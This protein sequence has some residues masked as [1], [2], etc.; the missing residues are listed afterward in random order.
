MTTEEPSS[1]KQPP[2]VE[3]SGAPKLPWGWTEKQDSDGVFYYVANTGETSYD[4]PTL[5]R[6]AVK[7]AERSSAPEWTEL[8]DSRTNERGLVRP[9]NYY[10]YNNYSGEIVTDK[11]PLYAKQSQ[12]DI[13][14]YLKAAIIIQ[15]MVRNHQGRRRCRVQRAHRM[16]LH[17]GSHLRWE[18][19]YD[20]HHKL[21]Y[22]FDLT[23]GVIRWDEPEQ[24][25]MYDY[26]LPKEE[27]KNYPK[28]S[29][30]WDPRTRVHYYF[31]NYQGTSQ[32]DI[33]FDW[34]NVMAAD[35]RRPPI[36][37]SALAMQC[38][39]RNRVIAQRIR[40]ATNA[41]NMS[42]ADRQKEVAAR[43]AD[44]ARK[45]A[46]AIIRRA[47]E[48]ER[49]AN[50]AMARAEAEQCSKGDKFWGIDFMIQAQKHRLEVERRLKLAEEEKKRRDE[51]E[52]Q[53]AIERRQEMFAGRKVEML[54]ERQRNKEMVEEERQ[55]TSIDRFWGVDRAEIDRK[56]RC[57]EMVVQDAESRERENYERL[58]ALHTL[59]LNEH[60]DKKRAEDLNKAR[61]QTATRE[62]YMSDFYRA[63]SSQNILSYRWPS[64]TFVS[65]LPHRWE[66]N[67]FRMDEV[68]DTTRIDAPA[69]VFHDLNSIRSAP[70]KAARDFLLS[71]DSQ[72]FNLLPHMHKIIDKQGVPPEID[73]R[74]ILSRQRTASSSLM[75]SNHLEWLELTGKTMPHMPEINANTR[76]G[77]L[78]KLKSRGMKKK[79][80]NENITG[81]K[82]VSINGD[83]I[84]ASQIFGELSVGMNMEGPASEI[85]RSAKKKK[86]TQKRPN[87][88]FK[89]ARMPRKKQLNSKE[90]RE[91]AKLAEANKVKFS[92]EQV[93]RF[94]LLF[95]LIDEDQSGHVDKHELMTALRVNDEV[96]SL[97]QKSPLLQPLLRDRD[98]ARTFMAMDTDGEGGVSYE[99]F[100]AFLLASATKESVKA[101]DDAFKKATMTE[102][103]VQRSMQEEE[104]NVDISS[105]VSSESS[106]KASEEAL[107]RRIFESVD[108]EGSGSMGKREFLFAFKSMPDVKKLCMK[109]QNLGPLSK[110]PGFN[111]ALMT[112]KTIDKDSVTLEE[113]NRF[114]V[115]GFKGK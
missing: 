87:S 56:R 60:R 36:L 91:Q 45:E 55:Q 63:E 24:S 71:V 74:E 79:V 48:K 34:K 49:S 95:V 115:V 18:K 83:D 108:Q 2:V 75:A 67:G 80:A 110:R 27:H 22:W 7:T 65:H 10:Y 69:S 85:S 93:E 19:N 73:A 47:E 15:N 54:Q 17:A 26:S 39:Y 78:K 100:E 38:L 13:P 12:G 58:S 23:N 66:T 72:G 14:I 106:K 64:S 86:T 77:R 94:K 105:L 9:G 29:K 59:W 84:E 37:K 109:S 82:S 53:K 5:P 3:V 68:Y 96:I 107:I 81:E 99:E 102:L 30:V 104:E 76:P 11:P 32:F 62:G 8:W 103:E 98:F 28:Y 35:M 70:P 44:L 92:E 46:Q 41:K 111:N 25:D 50:V 61:E 1:P 89:K 31:N 33:P 90:R 6:F 51:E 101:D 20:M 112:L 114:C 43:A 57:K 16:A 42:P 52:K 113:F 4:V 88:I 21:T 97:V 40:S